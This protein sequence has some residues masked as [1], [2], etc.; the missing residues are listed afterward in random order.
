MTKAVTTPEEK[1]ATSPEGVLGGAVMMAALILALGVAGL[2][3]GGGWGVFFGCLVPG[4]LFCVVAIISSYKDVRKAQQQQRVLETRKAVAHLEAE[5]GVPLLMEERSC[6][7]CGKPLVLGAKFCTDCG[8]S[9]EER[10]CGV[11]GAR[12]PVDA[13]YCNG[14]AA[15]LAPA[16]RYTA[17][18]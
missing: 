11:C 6:Q 15:E 7:R 17:R 14:C 16:T 10:V 5:V 12:N 18:P 3:G 2:V 1:K 9:T 4:E 13:H 8:Q